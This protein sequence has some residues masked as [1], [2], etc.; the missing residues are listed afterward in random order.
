MDFFLYQHKIGKNT[1][2]NAFKKGYS[3]K[4]VRTLFYG[5]V[6]IET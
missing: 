1:Y 6:L 4:C 5:R 2:D 3:E